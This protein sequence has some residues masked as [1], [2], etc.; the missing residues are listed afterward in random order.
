MVLP[1]PFGAD[2][3]GDA[4][5]WEA[6]AQVVD[7]QPIAEALADPRCLDHEIA[8][9]RSGRDVDLVGLVAP[10][11]FLRGQLFIALEAR[12]ALGMTALG[13]GAHPFELGPHRPEARLF[14]ALFLGQ[15]PFLLIEPGG[16]IALPGD[17][18]AAV[19]LQDP[20]RD[21]V[22]KIA[23][24][25]DRDHGAGELLQVSLQPGHR[26]RVQVIGGLVD[27][28]HVGVR[29]QEPAQGHAPALAARDARYV[30][31]PGRE[32][33]GI[34]RDVEP[35][36]QLP[37]TGAIDGLLQVGLLLEQAVHVLLAHG[38]GETCRDGVE[39]IE[40]GLRLP[41]PLLHV[42]AHVLA[43]VE[44]RFLRQEADGDPGHRDRFSV[45]VGVESGHD[46]KE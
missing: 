14:L 37:G 20:T 38:L 15:A 28:Q 44:R 12:L 24:V 43:G 31:I 21:V 7:E 4:A 45:V 42:A 3:P 23:V 11:E 25:G 17:P 46:P 39:A 18:V 16:V 34:G 26:L 29:E 22:E 40:Q 35:A 30:G 19:Q 27:E 5:A 33:Q 6:E 8:Q 36:L 10:L 32:A 2:D 13:V 1:A 41:H 9:A